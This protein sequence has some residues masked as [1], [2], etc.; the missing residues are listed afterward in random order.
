MKK[1][2]FII[3]LGI[4]SAFTT[5]AQETIVKG[6]VLDATT[7]KPIPDV[8]I[9]IE[10]TSQIATTNVNGEFQFTAIL[11]LGEQ[12]LKIEKI[13]YVTKRYPIVI[14]EGK[15]VDISGM[16]L[17]FDN[18]D[19]KDSFIISISD[20][21]LNSEDDGLTDNI[22]GLLQASRD[23]FLNAAAFDF[24]ATFFRPRGLDN[25]NGK[26]LINGIEM[27]KQFN[28]R[29]QW[30]NWGG[31]N[32][33]QRN[34]EFTMGMSANDYIFGD[35]AG[36][37]N[38]VMR[39]SKYRKGGRVSFASANRSYQG[40]VMGSYSS[41]LLE[42][43][44]SYSILASR[45]YGNEGFVD[46]TLYDSNSF[47]ASVEKRINDK[48]S[49]NFT[50]MYAQ[51]RRGRSTAITEEVYNLK[52]RT[53]N[54]FWG[55]VDGTLRN[56]RV[57]KIEE[58]IIMLN[59]YW[60]ISS[61]T[62]LNTNIAY[63][64]G[65]IG[66]SRIDNNGTRLVTFNGQ[67][68]YIG[69]A[70][71]PTPEYYQNLPS[72]LL[73]DQNP[74]AYDYEL[75]YLAQQ[76][77]INDGQL[78]W[79]DLYTANAT[80]VAQ[81]GNSTYIVQ[82][83]RNDDKQLSI[84]TIF[85]TELSENI[86]LNATLSYRKLKSE[87]YAVITDLLGG[88]GY[89]DIDAFAE[90]EAQD[91]VL[92]TL[93]QSNLRNPNRIAR[94]GDRYKYNY[95]I[96][97]DVVSGFVQA[98]F[99]YNK[100]DFYLGAN[101]SQTSYQRNGLYENGYFPNTINSNRANSFGKSEKLNF[102]NYGVKGGF[103]YKITGRHLIDVNASYFTKAPSIRNSFGNARQSNETVF[104]LESE[105]VQSIDVSYIFRSP[106]VKARLTSFYSGF[107]NGTDIGFFF[108]ESSSGFFVQEIQTNIERRNIGAELGIEAQVTPTI[109]LK[110]AASVGQYI[111]TNNPN[112][113]YTSA[114]LQNRLTY[115]SGTTQLKN[116]RVAGGP[117]RAFQL[118]FEYRDPNYWWIGA[119]A[120]QFSNAYVDVSALKRSDAFTMDT[121]LIDENLFSQGGN[122]SGSPFNDYDP[123]VARQLLKQEQFED[124]M[125][126]NIVG[127][128]SWKIKDYFVG[129][130]AAINNVFNK[131][132]R[133]G[134]F[135]QSRRVDYRSQITE[136]SNNA[137]P[138]FGNRYFYGN[139]T[140]YYL[141]LYVRF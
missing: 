59:H 16:T 116:Y 14:N 6:S 53:Y 15:T 57:R 2:L 134:G 84:N 37:N 92:A 49:L 79:N 86:K 119:T 12:V 88:T 23:V 124:Y 8:T 38:I 46:G 44:W 33:V 110:G 21:E 35:L 19:K 91:Q 40:R 75:A 13:G 140:T 97:A 137:G 52:G 89:L 81:G 1:R 31:L 48:H 70:R 118:G 117:E 82:E 73:R 55:E 96:D 67:D 109:K 60:D 29:P 34:R 61:K 17:E 108:T 129:F 77:F 66:N 141:N 45:R 90:E 139:G 4:F 10:E 128:K 42:G 85:D 20:D 99:K 100:V 26:V 133:T 9:T 36:T 132:Y 138:I 101:I 5:F 27:N 104:G 54:P 3:L 113:Y 56:S 115:G 65:S 24:S 22:S 107:K 126:V 11:P 103:T 95:E 76:E 50:G 136:Q 32:D 105:K 43:G 83:D 72:Y 18:S 58:P 112:L 64:F 127:G 74:T 131:E 51:N 123:N 94:E 122:I 125:L 80:V 39:A 30:A 69:G 114:D 78:N 120:N 98:Q 63:Q 130:F 71:N 28:G 47:F 135:E 111:F 68:T 7:G 93:A 62:R 41:G 102:S 87:N 106:I 121:D 25:A